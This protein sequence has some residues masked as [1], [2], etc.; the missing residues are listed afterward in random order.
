MKA[1]KTFPIAVKGEQWHEGF[2]RYHQ[3]YDLVPVG[4]MTLDRLGRILDVNDK[5]ARLLAFPAAA[6]CGPSRKPGGSRALCSM[7]PPQTHGCPT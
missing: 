5:A 3:L 2:G 4:F 7:P 6:R 1:S